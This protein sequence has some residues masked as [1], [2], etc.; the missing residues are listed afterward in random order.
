MSNA[1]LPKR[2]A[3][4]FDNSARRSIETRSRPILIMFGR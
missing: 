2:R 4:P 3:W 1:L